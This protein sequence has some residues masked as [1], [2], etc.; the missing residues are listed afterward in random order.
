MHNRIECI[1]YIECTRGVIHAMGNAIA[2]HVV[3]LP[4]IL[5]SRLA[6]LQQN[7]GTLCDAS[8]LVLFEMI[9]KLSVKCGTVCSPIRR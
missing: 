7:R 5:Q 4:A 3:S 8:Q 2:V 9:H 6:M 1:G